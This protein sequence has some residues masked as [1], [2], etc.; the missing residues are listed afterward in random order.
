EGKTAIL[1]PG[2]GAQYV[3]ML[4]DLACHFPAAHEVLAEATRIFTEEQGAEP[5]EPAA[6]AKGERLSLARAAGPRD[7][8]RRLSDYIYPRPAFTPEVK[9]AQDAALRATDIAQPALG[10]V[11]LGA[12]RVLEMFGATAD[13]AAG[14]SYGELTA[15]CAAGRL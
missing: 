3:G 6:R 9:A 11:S 12:W 2:Q 5:R 8:A 13:A 7:S 10:A 4:R 1:F 14:H 15:L